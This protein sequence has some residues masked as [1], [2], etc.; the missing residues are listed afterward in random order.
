MVL[1]FVFFDLFLF[2]VFL[3]DL[4]GICAL[5]FF[6]A[7]VIVNFDMELLSA[8]KGRANGVSELPYCRCRRVG[9]A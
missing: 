5:V 3:L 6:G 9:G 8:I 7:S 2:F 1:N 4:F